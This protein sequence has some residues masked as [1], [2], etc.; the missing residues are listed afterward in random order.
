MNCD[1]RA[2]E[3][4]GA[5]VRTQMTGPAAADL[6]AVGLGLMG[7]TT[8]GRAVRGATRVDPQTVGP[9]AATAQVGR[10][11]APEDDLHRNGWSNMRCVST[12]TATESSAVPNY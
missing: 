1:P 5:V 8:A 12:L 6:S 9:G 10:G 7:R 11:E 4:S 2:G 3:G